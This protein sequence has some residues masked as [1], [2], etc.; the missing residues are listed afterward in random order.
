MSK[1][2]RVELVRAFRANPLVETEEKFDIKTEPKK[3]YRHHKSKLPQ[4]HNLEVLCVHQDGYEGAHARNLSVISRY[5]LSTLT[6]QP[7]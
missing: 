6:D 2:Y 1:G 7:K 3:W 4:T 5:S